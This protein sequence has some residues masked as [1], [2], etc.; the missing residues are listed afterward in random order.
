VTAVASLRRL[1]RRLLRWQRYA[2]ATGW[3]TDWG[4]LIR[5]RLPAEWGYNSEAGQRSY[6]RRNRIP[7]GLARA[8]AAVDAEEE[9]RFLDE[10]P[11]VWLGGPE[12]E[13]ALLADLADP[14]CCLAGDAG[15]D[16]PCVIRCTGCRGDSRCP[17]CGGVDDLGCWHCDG[18]GGCP[19]GCD[20]GEIVLEGTW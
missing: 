14:R 20:D 3:T 17:E 9:R 5:S 13:A 19:R 1:N 16:G 15:H 7:L 8:A 12:G 2:I 18:T 4:K 11:E 10:T 6:A